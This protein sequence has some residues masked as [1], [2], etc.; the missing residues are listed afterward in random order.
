MDS[1]VQVLGDVT[2]A[3]C[4]L[5]GGTASRS[6]LHLL[7]V[8]HSPVLEPDLDLALGQHQSLGQF[9]AYRLGDV[10]R[11]HVDALQL[12]QLL[13]RVRTTLL[14]RARPRLQRRRRRGGVRPNAGYAA[15]AA[16]RRGFGE[17]PPARQRRSRRNIDRRTRYYRIAYN[18]RAMKQ[19]TFSSTSYNHFTVY[20]F[21]VR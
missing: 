11:R 6:P 13:L 1:L 5:G 21:K 19:L 17:S 16:W 8:F 7:L 10:H 2:H 12:R 3:Q 9:P 18:S 14:A 4:L 20:L 15:A